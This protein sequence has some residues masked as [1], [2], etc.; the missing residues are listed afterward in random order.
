VRT[1]KLIWGW[2]Q[3]HPYFLN[4]ISDNSNKKLVYE[5]YG[6]REYYI[7]DPQTRI[8]NSFVLKGK[9]FSKLPETKGIIDSSLLKTKIFF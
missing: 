8:V 2:L 1:A 4:I 3:N 9:I 6:V 7:V 5:Q